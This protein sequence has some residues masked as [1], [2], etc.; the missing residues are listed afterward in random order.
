MGRLPPFSVRL[1][2]RRQTPEKNREGA[3]M[4]SLPSHTSI[5]DL[6]EG[7]GDRGRGDSTVNAALELAVADAKSV[8]DRAA[9]FQVTLTPRAT[10]R[11]IP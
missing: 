3:P 5:G 7:A 10:R 11:P 8:G 2:T 9:G 1:D 4:R 6:L